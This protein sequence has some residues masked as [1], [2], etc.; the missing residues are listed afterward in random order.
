MDFRPVPARRFIHSMIGMARQDRYEDKKR[1]EN[2]IPLMR[3][4]L[5]YMM[6]AENDAERKFS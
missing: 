3:D 1:N 6:Q 2:F 5:G 4:D